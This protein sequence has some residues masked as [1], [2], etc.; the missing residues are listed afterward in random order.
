MGRDG[1]GGQ[2]RAGTGCEGKG[3]EEKRRYEKKIRG[4]ETEG[5]GGNVRKWG[6]EGGRKG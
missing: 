6:K 3:N 4:E 5:S 2:G 1:R